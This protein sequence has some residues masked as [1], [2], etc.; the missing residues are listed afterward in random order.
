[1]S[2]CELVSVLKA[3]DCPSGDQDGSRSLSQ[4]PLGVTI[5]L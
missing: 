4:P 1:M 5:F 2:N 3:M